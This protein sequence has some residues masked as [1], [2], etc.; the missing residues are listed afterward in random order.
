MSEDTVLGTELPDARVRGKTVEDVV[1][2]ISE[3]I[4]A[5]SS[6]VSDN[7]VGDNVLEDQ[8]S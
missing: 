5:K 4:D 8:S 2:L 7:I 3:G 6:K 1:T